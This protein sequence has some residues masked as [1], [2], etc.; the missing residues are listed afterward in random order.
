MSSHVVVF[1]VQHVHLLD[2]GEEDIKLIGV[3]STRDAAK[4]VIE[5]LKLK[6]GFRDAP[7]GFSIDAYTLDEDNWTEGY[8][9]VGRRGG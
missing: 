2:D 4:K 3:Y 5:R 6:P 8:V 9:T 7:A 1:I